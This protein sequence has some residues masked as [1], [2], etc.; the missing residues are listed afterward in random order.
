MEE[1]GC[2]P[3]FAACPEG[4]Q[5]GELKP[6]S[7]RAIVKRW[8]GN[9]ATKDRGKTNKTKPNSNQNAR[10]AVLQTSVLVFTVLSGFLLAEIGLSEGEQ[11]GGSSSPTVSDTT[12]SYCI[13][14]PWGRLDV[15]SGGKREH[16]NSCG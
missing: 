7:L 14:E 3:R 1:F 13:N 10:Q 8:Q 11:D 16:A 5:R 9:F 12:W 15:R 2:S 6:S 4:L